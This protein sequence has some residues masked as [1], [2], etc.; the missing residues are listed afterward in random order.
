MISTIHKLGLCFTITALI[1][2]SGCD[3]LSSPGSLTDGTSPEVPGDTISMQLET[4]ASVDVVSEMRS[5]N[6]PISI[7]NLPAECQKIKYLRYGL[8][9]KKGDGS[10]A[11]QVLVLMTGI[12]VSN[13]VMSFLGRE[14]VSM[15]QKER[16]IALEVWIPD[17][18][19]NSLED[20]TG[21][22]EAERTGNIDVAL[23][24]YYKGKAINGKTFKGYLLNK[25]V[26]YLADMGLKLIMEDVYTLIKTLVPDQKVRKKKVFVGGHSLGGFLAAFFSGWDFDGN[27]A[28]TNDAGYNN[29]A[30]I[31]GLDTIVSPFVDL[32][33][34]IMAML[35]GSIQAMVP[36]M[37]SGAYPIIVAG[38]KNSTL[39]RILPI[40]TMG[41]NSETYMLLELIG[42]LADTR[43]DEESTLLGKVPYSASVETLL[44]LVHSRSLVQ[45]LQ[46]DPS[47]A[48]YRF[49]NEA[50]LGVF[51]DDNF[52]PISIC[53]GSIGMLS[54]GAIVKKNFPLPDGLPEIPPLTDLISILFT[55]DNLYIADDKN[56]LYTWKN[57]NELGKDELAFTT[58]KAEVTDLH[59]IAATMYKGPSNLMEWYFPTRI[60]IDML[61]ATYPVSKKYGLNYFHHAKLEEQHVFLSLAG[62]GP[63][64]EPAKNAGI[65]VSQV[66][67]E[68]Y[69]HFDTLTAATD[70]PDRENEVFM[71]MIDF[72]IENTVK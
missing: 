2:F 40:K 38:L 48:D 61:M 50:L 70:N 63:F 32:F 28:T 3:D 23:D 13:N 71:P 37:A 11:D 66:T 27:P 49:T 29:C 53:N 18:R 16:G 22:E 58:Q 64:Y 6:A 7:A 26:P 41:F 34:P 59:T 15:A 47:I 24:Y 69:D 65:D 9:G 39:P 55:G 4:V 33:D 21:V 5:I 20:L 42:I 67:A 52:M 56:V 72:M 19:Y 57:Y 51:L 25:D 60:V 17:R 54:G 10:D 43:P 45:F 35:P 68:G 1:L 44:K 62:D 36:G 14:M 46:P 8:A 31:V 12:L 30:G